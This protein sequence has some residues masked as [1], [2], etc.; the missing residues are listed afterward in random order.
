[1]KDIVLTGQENNS[2]HHS[3]TEKDCYIHVVVLH[4][5]TDIRYRLVDKE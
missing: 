1:M 4:T 5:Q 2:P 3:I